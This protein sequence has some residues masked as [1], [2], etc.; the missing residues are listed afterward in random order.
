MYD[1]C[2]HCGCPCMT[3]VSIVG[4]HVWRDIMV[5]P[6]MTQHYG[7]PM[8]IGYGMITVCFESGLC[9][10]LIICHMIKYELSLPLISNQHLFKKSYTHQREGWRPNT[11]LIF[12]SQY[13]FYQKVKI[14]V[15]ISDIWYPYLPINQLHQM[16]SYLWKDWNPFQLHV[17]CFLFSM[18]SENSTLTICAFYLFLNWEDM[19]SV[20]DDFL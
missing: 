11:F 12:S 4:V 6:C 1:P 18:F 20:K 5:C 10:C 15:M 7:M 17:K 14:N 13:I 16:T 3:R 19:S 9:Q 8:H 2:Q